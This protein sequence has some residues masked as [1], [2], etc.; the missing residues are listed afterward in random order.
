ME[1]HTHMDTQKPPLLELFYTRIDASFCWQCKATP[2]QGL[3][4]A[5]L[6]HCDAEI[7]VCL[8]QCDM[9][10]GKSLPMPIGSI[11]GDAELTDRVMQ[12]F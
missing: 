5:S 6:I 4:L 11:Q 3:L 1:K 9:A 2:W 10:M 8:L 12:K 7:L